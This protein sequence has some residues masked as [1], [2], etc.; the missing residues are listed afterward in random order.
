VYVYLCVCVCVC[1]CVEWIDGMLCSG[2][3]ES[4]QGSLLIDAL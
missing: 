1:V 4:I 3:H 2:A